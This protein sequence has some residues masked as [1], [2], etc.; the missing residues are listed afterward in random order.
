[1][2]L[3]SYLIMQY[4]VPVLLDPDIKRQDQISDQK[5]LSKNHLVEVKL[6]CKKFQQ[7]K[8]KSITKY[9]PMNT[10]Q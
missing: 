2:Y 5:N 3:T 1:M 9:Y 10:Q 7:E 4:E 6:H 8:L